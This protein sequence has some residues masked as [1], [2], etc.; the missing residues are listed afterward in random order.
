MRAVVYREP[1]RVEVATVPEPT[2]LEPEDVVVGVTCAA[3]CGTDL[4]LVADGHGL[5]PGTVLGHEY[6]GTVLATGTSVRTVAV[7]DRVAGAD[8]TACGR[9]WWCRRGDHW[10]CAHRQFLGT[11]GAFG[12]ALPGAQAE[13]V[14]VPHADNTLR[15]LPYGVSDEA[16]V[17]LGDVLPTGYA[18]IQRADLRPGDTVAVV[19]GGPVGQLASLAAQACGAGPVVVVEPVA[20]RRA[21][22]A[23][24]GALAVG[25]DEA[26]EL[27]ASLTHGRGADAVVDALGAP[28][29]LDAAMALVRRR[30]TV[31][32]VGVPSVEHWS[33]PV[34]DAFVNEVTVRF[35][36]G[37]LMRDGDALTA[38]LETGVLDP[39]VVLTETVDMARAPDG[40]QAMAE[41]RTLKVLVTM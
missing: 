9:C 27:L 17:L 22:A 6:T 33:M 18:A 12:P 41:R 40:Y 38:L 23:D 13:R 10:E 34:R 36:I 28:R 26:S 30:G 5:P 37:D 4:H 16:A 20:D 32:S 35:A 15:P 1:G 31:C 7:G 25:P 39:T 21:L 11:G 8:F 14:R 29:G 3:V 24:N 2:V 19:G